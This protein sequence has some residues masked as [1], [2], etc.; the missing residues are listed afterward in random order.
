MD[1]RENTGEEKKKMTEE[2]KRKVTRGERKNQKIKILLLKRILEEETD[3]NHELTV[4]QIIQKLDAMDVTA[5]RKSVCDDISKLTEEPIGM[6]IVRTCHDRSF[7]YKLVHREF[8]LVELKLLVDCVQSARFITESK[9]K[10]LIRKLE[11][12]ASLADRSQLKRHMIISGRVKT[13][14]KAVYYSLDQIHAAVSQNHQLSF[15]YFAW[16]VDRKMKLK[17]NGKKYRV[18]PWA[19]CWDDEKYYL[20]GYDHDAD[21]IK[22]FRVDKMTDTEIVPEERQGR[23]LFRDYDLPNYTNRLFGMFEGEQERVTLIC[24]NSMANVIIDRF[25]RDIMIQKEDEEHFRAVVDVSVSRMF[26]GWIMAL[27]GVKIAGPE[28]VVRQMKEEIQRL[29]ENYF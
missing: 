17:H 3:E 15:R 16:D 6:D 20:V 14:N 7:Y 19:L 29:Q 27:D 1:E 9:S 8:E 22:N 11:S 5:E 25:G 18:S 13:E 12:F 24:K 4:A 28:Q 21:K 10:E 23:K 26:L 2:G